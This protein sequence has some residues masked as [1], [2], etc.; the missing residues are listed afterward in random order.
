M[1]VTLKNFWP[2]DRIERARTIKS[3]ALAMGM[4]MTIKNR[5]MRH[6]PMFLMSFSRDG[7]YVRSFFDAQEAE[8]WLDA[9]TKAERAQ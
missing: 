7:G 6:C 8:Q 2:A 9:I 3:K 5:G 4:Q 1:R